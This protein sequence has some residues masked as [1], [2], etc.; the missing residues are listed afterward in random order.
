[1]LKSLYTTSKF[2]DNYYLGG[3]FGQ[4]MVIIDKDLNIKKHFTTDHGL[5]NNLVYYL[6]TD[7]D[8]NVWLGTNDGISV[9][10]PNLPF[11]VFSEN[12]NLKEAAERAKWVQQQDR[13]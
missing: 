4:G 8:K 5:Q 11:S 9:L 7:I 12:E 1:M 3:L 10:Y 13:K 6:Y 2:D